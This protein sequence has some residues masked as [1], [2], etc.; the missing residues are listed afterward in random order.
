MGLEKEDPGVRNAEIVNDGQRLFNSHDWQNAIVRFR[1][2]LEICSQQKWKDGINYAERMIRDAYG[3][4]NLQ[5]VEDAKKELQENHLAQAMRLFNLSLKICK[6]HGWND[7]VKYATEQIGTVQQLLNKYQSQNVDLVKN[8]STA[9]R[10][11]GQKLTE[12]P[13]PKNPPK[14]SKSTKKKK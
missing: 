5:F 14:I 7:G 13:K 9:S 2:S 12:L 4:L 1:Q 6:D 8:L 11:Q 3:G 10:S